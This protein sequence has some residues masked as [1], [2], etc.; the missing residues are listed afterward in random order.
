MDVLS[1]WKG[2]EDEMSRPLQ[3]VECGNNMYTQNAYYI[4]NGKSLCWNHL[5]QELKVK[6][7]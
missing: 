2:V 1:L 5:Q 6:T 4:L 7:S 3:C